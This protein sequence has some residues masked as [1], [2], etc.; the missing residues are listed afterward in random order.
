[1][2]M[3]LMLMEIIFPIQISI[4]LRIRRVLHKKY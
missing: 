1:M 3:F 2:V 4:I